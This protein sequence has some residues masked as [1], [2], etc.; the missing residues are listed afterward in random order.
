[1]SQPPEPRR[2]AEEEPLV[3]TVIPVSPE[4]S[5]ELIQRLRSRIKEVAREAM[6]GVPEELKE[7]IIDQGFTVAAP[8]LSDAGVAVTIEPRGFR[9][10]ATRKI[11]G[12]A[13]LLEEIVYERSTPCFKILDALEEAEEEQRKALASLKGFDYNKYKSLNEALRD[14]LIKYCGDATVHAIYSIRSF[15]IA[16]DII[17]GA[18]QL[19]LPASIMPNTHKIRLGVLTD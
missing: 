14:A 4:R 12:I 9:Y 3:K 11:V 2:G 5:M 15:T 8:W 18:L 19:N 10:D 16:L 17:L 13:E 7:R 1:L 6:R